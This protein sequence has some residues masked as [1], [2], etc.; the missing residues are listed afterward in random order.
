MD[1]AR[2]TVVAG[3]AALFSIWLLAN[4]Q[5]L[6]SDEDSL[7]RFV[8]GLLLSTLILLRPKTGGPFEASPPWVL[9]ATSLAGALAAV[10]GI[11]FNVNQFEWLGIILVIFSCL[12]WALPPR[13]GR[14]LV[15]ALI[16]FY[17][18]HPLPG[19]VF[20]ALQIRMQVLSVWASEWMLHIL[21]HQ[22]WADGIVLRTG[23]H[24]FA[25]PEACSGMTTGVTVFLCSLG[26]AI[27]VRF[28]WFEVVI[29]VTLGLVQV[30]VLNIVRITHMVIA[31]PEMPRAWSE[32]FLHDTLGT[33]LIISVIL[34]QVEASIWRARRM[35]QIRKEEGIAA[36]DVERAEKATILPHFWRVLVRSAAI[37]LPCVILAAALGLAVYKR[38]DTHRAAMIA[39]SVP[40]MVSNSTERGLVAARKVLELDPSKHEIRAELAKGLILEKRYRDALEELALISDVHWEPTYDLMQAWCLYGVEDYENALA[41]L[42]LLPANL[43]NAPGVAMLRAEIAATRGDAVMVAENIISASQTSHYIDRV[44]AIYAFL[45]ANEQWEAIS[46]SDQDRPYATIEEADFAVRAHLRV[47]EPERAATALKLAISKWP[48]EL[49]FLDGLVALTR[50]RPEGEWRTRFLEILD[51]NVATLPAGRLAGHLLDC[52]ALERPD[53]GWKVFRRLRAL[54]PSA[55][56]LDFAI[57][58]YGDEWF[59]FRRTEV[60][61]SSAGLLA[62][63]DMRPVVRLTQG[64]P[65]SSA[66]WKQVPE[67]D[68]LLTAELRSRRAVALGDCIAKLVQRREEGQLSGRQYRLFADAQALAGRFEMAHEVLD[69]MAE[70]F[71]A[72]QGEA[73]IRHAELYAKD[74]DWQSVYEVLRAYREGLDAVPMA[75]NLLMANALLRMGFG[76]YALK[77]LDETAQDYPD[78][79]QVKSTQVAFWDHFGEDEEALALLRTHESDYSPDLL[80]RLLHDTGRF[81]EADKVA[82]TYGVTGLAAPTEKGQRLYAVPAEWAAARRWLEPP[83]AGQMLAAVS[84]LEPIATAGASP[85]TRG[86]AERNIAWLKS[87]G[88]GPGSEL[89]DWLAVARDDDERGAALYR[90]LSLLAQYRRYDEAEVIAASSVEYWPRSRAVWRAWIALSEGRRDVVDRALQAVPRDPDVWLANIITG[91]SEK[92]SEDWMQARIEEGLKLGM[93]PHA[94]IRAGDFLLRKGLLGP[95]IAAAHTV[96]EADPT[97]LSSAMLS[98]R[99]AIA[100]KDMKWAEHASGRGAQNAFEPWPFYEAMVQIK[101]GADL[102][103]PQVVKALEYLR[104]KFTDNL[105][106]SR[107]LGDIYF[108]QGDMARALSVLKPTLSRDTEALSPYWFLVTAEAAR[109]AGKPGDAITVLR[110][111]R[112]VYPADRNVLNNLVHS[113]AEQPRLLVEARALLEDDLLKGGELDFGMLDTAAFVYLRAGEMDQALGF[114]DRAL[115]EADQSDPAWPYVALNAAEIR[116]HLGNLEDARE[117][118]EAV[119]QQ[120]IGAQDPLANQRALKILRQIARE[121]ERRR[122]ENA[123][124]TP[125]E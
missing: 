41:R 102:H 28:R 101:W 83:T 119:R 65:L 29:L 106:W 118:V 21:N 12:R 51:L 39:R 47:N 68:T 37:I 80:A 1:I 76:A 32:N 85:F 50:L 11:V 93:S 66:L 116:F 100:V 55:P 84:D 3:A 56:V 89:D 81:R 86:M 24:T 92:R 64:M 94:M 67:L 46:R 75:V 27:L 6:Q 15:L 113:L 79:A 23:G 73:T 30:V 121:E 7:I 40:G 33:Y 108:K 111:A 125:P 114:S 52:F 49:R 57:A 25:V 59:R 78:T 107:M 35:K 18:I 20:G 82:A 19:Q 90:L 34:V 70:K 115:A 22:A 44:R 104:T 98:L 61:M 124:A 10:T 103:D 13:F 87:A 5:W 45:A 109:Q 17:W 48:D 58:R 36:G 74:D 110:R 123:A 112:A 9:W 8:L 71:P 63:I 26:T 95:A 43:V 72:L 97:S 88:E 4:W 96:E 2:K 60:G 14:D 117:R 122:L 38:R 69:E 42:D 91:A 16:L 31:A 105:R 62:W 120:K 53:V 77:V 54:A 99:C